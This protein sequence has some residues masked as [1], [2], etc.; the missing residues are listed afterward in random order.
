[1]TTSGTVTELAGNLY[2]A[3]AM[4]RIHYL[5]R[6][7][8][9]PSAMDVEGLAQYWKDHYNTYLGAGTP[10]KAVKMYYQYAV[11]D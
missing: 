3:T 4:A 10:E 7:E 9:L 6:P 8:R 5:R 2:Y 11:V 1:M